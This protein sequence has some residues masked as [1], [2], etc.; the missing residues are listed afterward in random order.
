MTAAD[1]ADDAVGEPTAPRDLA[2]PGH[3]QH[4]RAIEDEDDTDRRAKDLDV[5][6][7]EKP[8]GRRARRA[9]RRAR[10]ASSFL[11]MQARAAPRP[12]TAP[13]R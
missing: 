2:L 3:Q 4:R 1:P 13:A 11:Q 12:A 10:R 7:G 5:D 6:I 8:D 9:R